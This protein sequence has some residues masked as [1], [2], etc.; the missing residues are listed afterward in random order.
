M[1]VSKKDPI[2]QSKDAETKDVG[3][4]VPIR[5]QTPQNGNTV[6][7]A[8][9]VVGTFDPV[10]NPTAVSCQLFQPG[11]ATPVGNPVVT[12]AQGFFPARGV[13]KVA[14]TGVAASTYDI[15][16][17]LVGGGGTSITT[18]N[19]VVAATPLL[20]ITMPAPAADIGAL[21]VPIQVAFA[22]GHTLQTMSVEIRNAA[23]S[24]DQSLPNSGVARVRMWRADLTGNAGEAHYVAVSASDGAG[25]T[26]SASVG[27]L[28]LS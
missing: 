12:N 23:D 6:G 4:R 28:K 20:A 8:F 15:K 24:A 18:P 1:T 19:V 10:G 21:D 11:T 27:G 16:A 3:V 25:N 5:I 13:W 7:P 17:T 9:A 26:V 22:S 2:H 14:F